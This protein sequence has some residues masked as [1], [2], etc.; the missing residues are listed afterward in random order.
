MPQ[1]KKKQ[2]PQANRKVLEAQHRNDFFKRLGAFSTI[3]TGENVLALLPERAWEQ[4]YLYRPR[5]V[6]VFP[7]EGCDI[8]CDKINYLK[9]CVNLWFKQNEIHLVNITRKVRFSDYYEF[10]VPLYVLYHWAGNMA[11]RNAEK[12]KLLLKE[13]FGDLD[14]VEKNL[15]LELKMVAISNL[16]IT[17]NDFSENFY[18]FRIETTYDQKELRAIFKIF[19]K[20]LPVESVKVMLDD[21][22]RSVYRIGWTYGDDNIEWK[23]LK[24]S[25]LGITT[26]SDNETVPVYIQKHAMQRLRERLDSIHPSYLNYHVCIA[27]HHCNC[28]KS[29]NKFLIE[30]SLFK[31]KVG[32]LLAVLYEGKLIIKTFLFLTCTDT[33]E[34]RKLEQLLGLKK[35]DTAFLKMERLS[36]FMPAHLKGNEELRAIFEKV[37]CPHLLNLH[38]KLDIYST[39]HPKQTLLEIVPQYIK[40]EAG[41]PLERINEICDDDLLMATAS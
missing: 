31:E 17:C 9:A 34:G 35:L 30:Y 7:E 12:V 23:N 20:R 33:P 40:K 27:L 39:V 18:S 14:I 4:I 37:G 6:M 3:A 2:N 15:I 16:L 29:G 11:N 36:T 32:Y 19:V 41:T 26:N 21:N 28:I 8:P 13:D 25:L 38:E 1:K 24:L 22:L 5:F 10:C